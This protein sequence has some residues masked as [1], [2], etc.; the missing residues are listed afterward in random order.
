MAKKK[1]TAPESPEV[2]EKVVTVTPSAEDRYRAA[3]EASYKSY[4][5]SE[6]V[7]ERD[8]LFDTIRTRIGDATFKVQCRYQIVCELLKK[9]GMA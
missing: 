1:D 8:R 2:Q 4:T 9:M 3:M 5:R 7:D 6:L